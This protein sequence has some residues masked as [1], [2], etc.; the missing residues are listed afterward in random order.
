MTSRT[1]DHT[2][3]CRVLALAGDPA[4]LGGAVTVALC[5]HWEHDGPCRWEHLTTSE[6]DGDGA[7]VTV[8][9]DASTEDE[10][11]VRDLIRSALA[12]GSLVGPDGTTTTWQLAP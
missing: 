9:F 4:A 2:E 1:W 8:S 11:Q 5:G 12:A 10:Q 6:A 7:V 3:V